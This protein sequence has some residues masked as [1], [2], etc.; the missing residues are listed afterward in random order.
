[1]PFVRLSGIGFAIA[2]DDSVFAGRNGCF[3]GKLPLRRFAVVARQIELAERQCLLAGIVDF[4]PRLRFSL[5][6][7][8]SVA[9][10]CLC[11]VEPQQRQVGCFAPIGVL[12]TRSGRFSSPHR[13]DQ[14][15]SE[16]DVATV[17]VGLMHF[18]GKDVLSFR[19]RFGRKGKRAFPFRIGHGSSGKGSKRNV[20]GAHSDPKHFHSVKIDNGTVV[21]NQGGF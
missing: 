12:P 4:H 11:F 21:H 13:A 14:G 3:V 5:P 7:D 1:M 8:N 17:C 16:H 9:V 10:D 2:P 15:Q 19:Q 20:A 18:D 6:V